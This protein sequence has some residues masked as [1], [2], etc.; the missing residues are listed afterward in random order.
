MNARI[1]Q[2]SFDLLQRDFE[3][4]L[5]YVE[6][7][8]ANAT[9]H[10][11]RAY[12][13]LLRTCTEFESLARDLL[14]D[15]GSKKPRE[16]MNVNDYRGLETGFQLE[17][18][19]VDFLGWRPEPRR[20]PPYRGW[21]TSQPPLAWYRDYNTVKHNRDAE[22]HLANLGTLLE[23]LAALFAL[24]AKA[25]N[26]NWNPCS[27]SRDKDGGSFWRGPFRLL[28]PS[29]TIPGTS[30]SPSSTGGGPVGALA[31]E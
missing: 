5:E 10:S 29:L 16:D 4:F 12:G 7:V 31:A 11:H 15:S 26:L 18:C 27:W 2:A 30:K 24:T 19:V 20:V 22:F 6:P 25:S 21:S 17:A 9:C 23:A 13:L 14:V 28:D 1:Y 3:T 8:E